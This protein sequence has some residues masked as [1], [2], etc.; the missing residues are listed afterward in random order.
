MKKILVPVIALFLIL[1]PIHSL[2]AETNQVC[3]SQGTRLVLRSDLC[4]SRST[5][6]KHQFPTIRIPRW[7]NADQKS[8]RVIYNSRGKTL[9]RVPS[10]TVPVPKQ[11][12]FQPSP[13]PAK[14]APVST[15]PLAPT[16]A[17]EPTPAPAQEPANFSAMQKEMLGYINAERASANLPSL[18]LDQKLCQ[19]AYLKSRDMAVN[20]YF[21]HTSPTYGS[22]FEMMK[23]QGITY[24]TAGENIAKN[25]SVKGAHNAFM[26]SAGHKANILNPGFGKL[27]LGFYQEG[28]YLYVTQWFTN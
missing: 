12:T 1:V 26:N 20:G 24:R 4:R 3:S 23:S 18:T 9:T 13:V 22:P 27:G 15:Q 6:V 21:S 11:P 5:S 8:V 2:K 17:P 7:D 25:T 16:P 14:P 19:G 10:Q 28:Q